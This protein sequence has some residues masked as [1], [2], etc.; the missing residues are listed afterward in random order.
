MWV[1]L[2]LT[3]AGVT[4]AF[5]FAS[6]GRRAAAHAGAGGLIVLDQSDFRQ[7]PG[8]AVGI[9]SNPLPMFGIVPEFS[10][11]DQRGEPF[12]S[13]QLIGHPWIADFIFTR[14]AGQCLGMAV[15]MQE[16]QAQL[17]SESEVRLVSFSVDPEYD[18]PE[19]LARYAVEHG[20]QF[21]RWV[22]LTGERSTIYQLSVEGFRLGVAEG[23]PSDAEPIL[24]ST[25]LVLVDA[26]GRIRGYYDATEPPAVDRLLQ[27]VE[28]VQR[29]R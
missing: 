13:S 27:D 14:C 17:P 15:R 20:A 10:L 16:V 8:E 2:A 18:T 23:A 24:H 4:L 21:G 29:E 5:L 28:R 7:P 1:V 3:I 26:D 11:V 25:R 22:F 9:A 6:Y 12:G 19:V